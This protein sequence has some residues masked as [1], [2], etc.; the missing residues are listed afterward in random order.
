LLLLWPMSVALTWLVAQ[1]IANRPYD[2][3][4][5][6]L[7]RGAVARGDQRV[8]AAG[9]EG[10][11]RAAEAGTQRQPAAAQRRGPTQQ[12]FQVLGRKGELI[13]GSAELPVPEEHVKPSRELRRFATM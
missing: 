10:A 9:Q 5:G 3:D 12:F 1:G 11:R 4:L 6:D 8:V 7:L 2:R 13:A